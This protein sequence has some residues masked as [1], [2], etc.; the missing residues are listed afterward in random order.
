M[1]G[2]WN[3]IRE[4][5]N[6]TVNDFREKGAVGAL[7]DAVL[8]T[9][10]L[11]ADTGGWIYNNVKGAVATDDEYARPVIN[12][13]GAL[14]VRGTTVAVTFP[15]GTEAEALVMGVD[16]ISVPPQARV[17]LP[18]SGQELVVEIFDTEKV[19]EG[20]H[21]CDATPLEST[22]DT[23]P[24]AESGSLLDGLRSEFHATVQDIREKGAVGAVKDAALDSVDILR[25]VGGT[26]VNGARSLLQGNESGAAGPDG[27]VAE[28]SVDGA[29]QDGSLLDGLRP[30]QD[31]L[32]QEWQNTMQE[33]KEKGAVGA[34]KDATLDAVDLLGDATYSA[35]G[36]T[37]NLAG[38]VVTTARASLGDLSGFDPFAPSSNEAAPAQPAVGATT[39][40]A[41]A[42]AGGAAAAATAAAVASSAA[43]AAETTKEAT[44][45][46]VPTSLG[47]AA[48]AAEEP[49][50]PAEPAKQAAAPAGDAKAMPTG[51][52]K[53]AAPEVPKVSLPKVAAPPVIPMSARAEGGESLKAKG[54]SIVSMRRNMFEKKAEEKKGDEEEESID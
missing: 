52:Y 45:T 33:F 32:A 41:A 18:D 42:V 36:A 54:K 31:R 47:P 53:A 51:G 14:P 3:L 28:R 8:D 15:D 44:P 5:V 48:A 35:V 2:L 9:R 7:K 29:N 17:V 27:T 25:S 16:A 37:K 21:E 43:P 19:S 50:K 4:E 39:A 1:A 10:D 26:A 34:M 49:A 11:A 13:A 20:E 40:A 12:V 30:V 23:P 46:A 24:P 38:S 6:A 22:A